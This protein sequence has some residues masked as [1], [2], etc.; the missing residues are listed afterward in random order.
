[1]TTLESAEE[2]WIS[3]ED[4][5]NYGVRVLREKVPFIW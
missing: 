1:M 5:Q 3:R 2:L 4:W